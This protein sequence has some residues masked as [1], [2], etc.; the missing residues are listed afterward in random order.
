MAGSI[1]A[2]RNWI[3]LRVQD[4]PDKMETPT[5]PAVSLLI[6]AYNEEQYLAPVLERMHASFAAMGFADYEIVVCDN[7]SSDRTAEV[8]RAGGARVV[9]EPHNQISRARNTAARAARGRWLIFVDA[10]TLVS[11]ELL[12]ATLR[13]FEGGRVCAGGAA[14]KF[15]LEDLHCTAASMLWVWNRVSA[16]ARLAAGSY[17]Y[18]YRQAWEECGGFDERV[19]AGEE[20]YFSRRLKRW[21]RQHGLRF[22]ILTETPVVTSARKVEWYGQGEL[23]WSALKML[24]P[25]AVKRRDDCGL[26]YT[27]PVEGTQK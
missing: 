2:R 20:I 8:A 4:D 23:L 17:V 25:G 16:L 10:D 7:N 1:A 12:A 3:K 9:H 24:R 6:P 14:L 21:A 26:W 18:C 22:E 15:G 13:R 27:R 5:T 19:Y 11:P